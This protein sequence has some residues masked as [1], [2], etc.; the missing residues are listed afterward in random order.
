M[1]LTTGILLFDD[2][3]DDATG[4]GI[5]FAAG[6]EFELSYGE[7]PF[8]AGYVPLTPNQPPNGARWQG[9]TVMEAPEPSAGWLGWV[10]FAGLAQFRRRRAA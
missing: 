8:P 5:A 1:S 7:L 9:L 10:G 4:L 6:A 2:A 3:E